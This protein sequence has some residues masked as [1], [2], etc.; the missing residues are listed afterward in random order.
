[1]GRDAAKRDPSNLP[2]AL[3]CRPKARYLSTAQCR[4]WL[5]NLVVEVPYVR[6]GDI[7][8]G[9]ETP[10]TCWQDGGGPWKPGTR[11]N[12][13]T[14]TT[15]S[16]LSVSYPYKWL[17]IYTHTHTLSQSSCLPIRV[18]FFPSFLSRYSIHGLWMNNNYGVPLSQPLLT[19]QIRGLLPGSAISTR[20]CLKTESRRACNQRLIN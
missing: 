14:G 13:Q 4:T 6:L 1:M 12:C 3:G 15:L 19:M 5:G 17:Y 18:S 8:R 7:P 2:K 16:K 11:R 9:Q 10:E 20:S